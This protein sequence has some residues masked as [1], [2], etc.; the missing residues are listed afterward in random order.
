[1][2]AYVAVHPSGT[3]F[4]AAALANIEAHRRA[5]PARFA[6]A[7][8]G[9][10][11]AQVGTE[12]LML[13]VSSS[14]MRQEADGRWFIDQTALVRSFYAAYPDQYDYLVF[15]TPPGGTIEGNN[16]YHTTLRWTATGLGAL[17][18]DHPAARYTARAVG[19]TVLTPTFWTADDAGAHELH[20]FMHQFC[21]YIQLP[22][23]ITGGAFG[24]VTPNGHF[25]RWFEVGQTLMDQQWRD[26]ELVD[27][28]NNTFK[29]VYTWTGFNKTWTYS[30]LELYLAGLL[31]ASSVGPMTF[32]RLAAVPTCSYNT[33]CV[34]AGVIYPGTAV[35]VT[36]SDVI[37]ANGPR[38]DR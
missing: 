15:G 12:T 24:P 1:M 35:P 37:A 6:T 21:C 9:L 5:F 32:I 36:M 27:Q 23:A 31:P 4:D 14:V 11:A 8:R 2:F 10:S 19:L 34:S 3:S 29:A 25:V 20:E 17:Y 28:R 18:A 26:S 38:T 30:D 22:S 13:D 33:Y 7:T 16:G